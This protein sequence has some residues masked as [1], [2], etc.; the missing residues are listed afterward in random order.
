MPV[1]FSAELQ[2][3]I[4]LQL[5]VSGAVVTTGIISSKLRGSFLADRE[6][7]GRSELNRADKTDSHERQ[8]LCGPRR[9]VPFLFIG[10]ERF[11]RSNAREQEQ[12]GVSIDLHRDF[13]SHGVRG[14]QRA[15]YYRAAD[16]H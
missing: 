14:R 13:F 10:S 7:N 5:W 8:R 4:I 11:D 9:A 6:R 2:P 3:I 15:I 12:K 16:V 1:V